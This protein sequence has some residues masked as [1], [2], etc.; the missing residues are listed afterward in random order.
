MVYCIGAVKVLS[1]NTDNNIGDLLG[2]YGAIQV[3]ARNR[4]DQEILIPDWLITSH[5]TII[6]IYDWMFTTIYLFRRSTGI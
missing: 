1:A 2:Q 5:V 4:P 6:T 3:I